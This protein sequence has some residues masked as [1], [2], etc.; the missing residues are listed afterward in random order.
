MR[1]DSFKHVVVILCVC[2]LAGCA[3]ARPSKKVPAVSAELSLKELCDRHNISF[4]L[5]S[6]SQAIFLYGGAGTANAMVG[7]DIVLV[8][9]EKVVLSAPLKLQRG[10]VIVPADFKEK[11]T[12]RLLQQISRKEDF[13]IRKIRKV[14]VDAGHGGKDPGAIGASRLYEKT[15]V[16][17]IAQKFKQILER[18]GIKVVMTRRT[19][20]FI[21]LKDRTVLASESKADLFV[22]I[23]ANAHDRR[24]VNGIEVYSLKDLDFFELNDLQRQENQETLYRQLSMHQ[25]D[26]NL[27]SIVG[28]ML[29]TYKQGQ[30]VQLAQEL[31]QQAAGY[32]KAKNL[33]AKTSR[34]FVLRNTLIPAILVEVGYL[35]NPKEEKLLKDKGYRQ[36]LAHAL[37][38]G[39]LD[40][41]NSQ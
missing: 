41:I 36:K 6:V 17:D 21:S 11:V 33:G 5:D 15:V 39:I 3:T 10:A 26:E 18:H 25:S 23:H 28:D 24:S 38:R 14:V 9:D 34:F 29:Y 12:D 31:S 40:Y 37:A 20:E 30:S 22:S 27:K 16:L 19:D 35:S 13:S 4:S 2:L 8:D 32:V 1:K 7:S